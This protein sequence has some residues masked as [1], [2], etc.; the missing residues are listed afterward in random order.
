MVKEIVEMIGRAVVAK[1]KPAV[2]LSGGIDSA[3]LLYHLRQKTNEIHSYTIGFREADPFFR[4]AREVARHFNVPHK[5]L[6]LSPAELLRVYREIIPYLPRPSFDLWVYPLA[7]LAKADGRETVYTGDGLDEHFGGYWYRS[8]SYL[9]D[10][11]VALAWQIPPRR[12]IYKVLGLSWE[13]PFLKLSFHET[14][15]YYDPL[16]QK[17]LLREAYRD[18]L[19]E[20]I[21]SRRK[22]RGGVSYWALWYEALRYELPFREPRDEEDIRTYF[23]YW[24]SQVW[25]E[26]KREIL[27]EEQGW[28]PSRGLTSL[29]MKEQS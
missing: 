23:H 22:R 13:A 14:L 11:A 18:I 15:R 4:E 16:K 20:F 28:K 12:T 9:E 1:S 10:W 3:I 26:S 2:F 19:P 7:K 29:K 21:I 27:Q 24:A 6:C 17:T 8:S 5:E 25:L